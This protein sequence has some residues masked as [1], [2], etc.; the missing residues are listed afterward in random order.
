MNSASLLIIR[1]ALTVQFLG[2]LAV[3]SL[4]AAAES[5]RGTWMAEWLNPNQGPVLS[6]SKGRS[7]GVLT[8]R[9]GKLSFSEQVGEVG[10]EVELSNVRKVAAANDGRALSIQ[11]VGGAEYI[12]VIMDPSLTRMSPK[13][14]L[15]VLE[16]ALQLQAANTR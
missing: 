3:P 5:P 11:T 12:A 2:V 8:L 4:L 1:L 15:S 16:R 10:W 14:V 6:E 13:K 7:M 9:D